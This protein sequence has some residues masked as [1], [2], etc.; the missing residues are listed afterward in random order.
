MKKKKQEL[1]IPFV[2]LK[3]GVHHFEFD[4]DSTF[5]EQFDFSIIKKGEFKVEVIFEKRTNMFNLAFDMVGSLFLNCD[6]CNDEM[7]IPV[8]GKE[9]LIVKFGSESYD[10]TDEIKIISSSEHELNI[11]ADIYEFIHLLYPSRVVHQSSK[12]CNAEVIEKLKEL[13]KEKENK[14]V[15]PRWSALSKLKDNND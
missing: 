3:E 6:R 9:E 5:F 12:E 8:K 4:I 13:N 10:Q 11:T 15:D 7:E 14:A 1:V 2:G